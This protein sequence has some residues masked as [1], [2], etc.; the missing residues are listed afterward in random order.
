MS[1]PDKPKIGDVLW[2]QPGRSFYGRKEYPTGYQVRVYKVGRIYLDAEQVDRPGY[3]HRLAIKSIPG[4]DGD[5]A[6]VWESREAWEHYLSMTVEWGKLLAELRGL[7]WHSM[8][9][10]ISRDDI[11]TVRRLLGIAPK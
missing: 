7:Y 3:T 5:S 11:A 1:I 10:G 6:S 4:F 9:A 2:Y 8:P